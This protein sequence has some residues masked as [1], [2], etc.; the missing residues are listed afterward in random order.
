MAAREG[1][2]ATHRFMRGSPRSGSEGSCCAAAAG[3]RAVSVAG[4]G[5]T[6]RLLEGLS[7]AAPEE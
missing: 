4:A 5:E 6:G 2:V 7:T 1:P 3:A